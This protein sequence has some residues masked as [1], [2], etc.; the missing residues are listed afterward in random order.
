M[1]NEKIQCDC[2][3]VQIEEPILEIIN[4]SWPL[5]FLHLAVVLSPM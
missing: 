1:L 5:A 4:P 3:W 2:H